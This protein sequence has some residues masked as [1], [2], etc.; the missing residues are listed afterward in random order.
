VWEY[1]VV[2]VSRDN[3]G[4]EVTRQVVGV[5]ALQPAEQRSFTLSVEVFGRAEIVPTLKG[6]KKP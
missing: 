1:S 5:G 6:L 4:I 2:L 3:A